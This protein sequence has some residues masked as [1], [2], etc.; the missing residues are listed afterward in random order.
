[1]KKKKVQ[2]LKVFPSGM[3]GKEYEKIISFIEKKAEEAAQTVAE[4]RQ[5][6]ILSILRC[7]ATDVG[8][9]ESTEI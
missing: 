1:M 3:E 4:D 8:I 7:I 6:A 5:S 2:E 9:D